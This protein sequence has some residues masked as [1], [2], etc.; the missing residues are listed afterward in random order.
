MDAPFWGDPAP[1][2]PV[3]STDQLWEYEVVEVFVAGEAQERGI[4]YL[5]MEFSPH[6]HFLLL[7][8]FAPRQREMIHLPCHFRA[9]QEGT[10]WKGE[11]QIEE[12]FF[13]PQP[14][15]WNAYAIHSSPTQRI[16]CA[17]APV[18]GEKP[19]FHQPTAFLPLRLDG[20]TISREG[21]A[22]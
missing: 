8:F 11:A 21:V 16:Y 14:W 13:P 20:A 15:H 10:R 22:S 6:G 1:Q 4:P 3:G 17:A 18:K 5:E 7:R 2:A 19:D 9:L 12:R